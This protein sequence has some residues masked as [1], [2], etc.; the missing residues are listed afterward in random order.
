MD[1]TITLY[2]NGSHSLYLDGVAWFSTQF[3]TWIPFL[4]G[5][6]YILLRSY[7]LKEFLW[8]VA[9]LILCVLICDQSSSALFKPLIG[10]YRPSQNP[11][12]SHLVDTVQAYRGAQFGFFSAHA[13]NTISVATFCSLLLR[14]RYVTYPLIAWSILNCW[15]RLYL[16]V[17][18]LGD[19]LIGLLYGTIVGAIIFLIFLRSRST[20]THSPPPKKL[21]RLLPLLFLLSL[22]FTTIPWKHCF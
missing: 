11:Y 20:H 16:G 22:C 21:L 3:F 15:T 5:L 14:H 18:Y 1:S 4:L 9:A 7:K 13:A 6:L 17:H 19:I 10:R 2:I 8:I 12:I